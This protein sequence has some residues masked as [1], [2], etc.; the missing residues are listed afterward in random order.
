MAAHD[1]P[2]EH[3]T[4]WTHLPSSESR[5]AEWSSPALWLAIAW[6]MSYVIHWMQSS[7]EME[8]EL[9]SGS[10]S[11]SLSLSGCS[12]GC[13]L[14]WRGMIPGCVRPSFP[15]HHPP[16]RAG[17]GDLCAAAFRASTSGTWADSQALLA[18]EVSAAIAIAAYLGVQ[19]VRSR[20][21][22]RADGDGVGHALDEWVSQHVRSAPPLSRAGTSTA[23]GHEAHALANS[24]GSMV[25]DTRRAMSM[26][27]D[28]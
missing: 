18:I 26:R 14:R 16:V 20:V 1:D 22:D 13:M 6:L 4:E 21:H 2:N 7:L 11:C 25:L 3:D 24:D 9:L 19:H 28:E 10:Q 12:K 23:T 8:E 15:A 27:L 17:T 5:D